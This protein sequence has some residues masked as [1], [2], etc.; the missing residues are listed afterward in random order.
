MR[1]PQQIIQA[2]YNTFALKA[3]RGPIG[4]GLI[5]IGGWGASNAVS[6]MRSRRFSIAGVYDIQERVARRFANRFGTQCYDHVDDLLAEPAIQAVCITVP[7]HFHVDSVKTAAN[8][9]KHIFIEK[10][11][12]SHSND[13]RALGQYCEDKQVILQVGH[14]MRRE[15]VFREIKRILETGDLGRPLYVQGV[16]TLDRRTRDDWRRDA[17]SCPGGSME[18]LGVHLLDVLTYLL[19]SPLASQDWVR[20]MPKQSSDPDWSGVSLIFLG[21][22]RASICTSFS[23]PNHM[24]L[25]M[26]FEE[27]RLA[28]DGKTISIA[29]KNRKLKTYRPHG[30]SGSVSQFVEFA[31]CI[32]LGKQPETGATEAAV[33]MAAVQS[34]LSTEEA[35]AS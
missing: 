2:I 18:Q 15:P 13:C 29:S 24:G 26:F 6:I 28:T 30:T 3:N 21:E 1:S 12:A 8:A 11:L 9:G 5:G 7:N 4:V 34:M 27:G 22:V 31:D 14:Q 33:V 20:N 35:P 23:S 10:P 32:E 16:Y 17:R 25:E 19:G